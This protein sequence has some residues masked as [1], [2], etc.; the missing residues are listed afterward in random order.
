MRHRTVK[1]CWTAG[2]TMLA[3]VAAAM[4]ITAFGMGCKGAGWRAL[5]ATQNARD[6]AA[7]QLAASA[8]A[9]HKECLAAHGSKT[10]GF[11]ECIKDH[12]DALRHWGDI[13]RPVINSSISITAAAL[14][15]AERVKG[16]KANVIELLKP[17]VCTLVRVAKAWA[18]FY[19]AAKD[20]IL[21][22]LK[23]AEGVSCGD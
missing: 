6:L 4:M 16:A 23:F 8:H 11:A 18:H 5:D 9:K 21:G 10:A 17:A 3:M 14:L 2:L 22:A 12:R 1:Q 13:A 20:T 7:K 15:I 19:G